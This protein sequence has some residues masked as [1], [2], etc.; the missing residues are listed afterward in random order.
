MA[1]INGWE[2]KGTLSDRM[3]GREVLK[4]IRRKYQEKRWEADALIQASWKYGISARAA[5]D[6]SWFA[7][8]RVR[9]IPA[10]FV[11]EEGEGW[12]EKTSAES[13]V[14]VALPRAKRYSTGIQNAMPRPTVNPRKQVFVMAARAAATKARPAA[15][16]AAKPTRSKAKAQVEVEEVED[17]LEEDELEDEEDEDLEDEEDE[18]DD[19]LEDE[20]EDEDEDEDDEDED[21]EDEEEDEEDEDEE[22]ASDYSFYASK[23]ITPTMQDF[24]E[25]MDQEIF[26]PVGSSIKEVGKT[27]PVRLIAI[28]GTARMEFQKSDLN[29]ERRA[30][31]QAEAAAAKAKPTVVKGAKSATKA[32]AKPTTKA[33]AKPATK[34]A[35]KPVARPAAKATATKPAAKKGTAAR[36]KSPF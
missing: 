15:K 4:Y 10:R 9:E 34:A 20:L 5:G 2:V 8:H 22:S 25:W 21:E 35:A 33:A 1:K 12:P 31:R 13:R 14:S 7:I 36:R 18:D 23:A 29:K 30:Q 26:V 27:D 11:I 28:A 32:A 17:E 3:T 19:D 24:A 16:P 6:G